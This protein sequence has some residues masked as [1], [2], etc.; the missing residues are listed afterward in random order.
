MRIS[1]VERS[2]SLLTIDRGLRGA[3]AVG[4]S[5]WLSRR[6]PVSVHSRCGGTSCGGRLVLRGHGGLVGQD[7]DGEEEGGGQEAE[8]GETHLVICK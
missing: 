6:A 8:L 3:V 2:G 1:G 5:C 7:G 4:V